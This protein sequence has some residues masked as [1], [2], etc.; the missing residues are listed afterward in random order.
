MNRLLVWKTEIDATGCVTLDPR[1]AK[2]VREVLKA[3]AGD[4]LKAGFVN[5]ALAEACVVSVD[6]TQCIVTMRATNEPLPPPPT[7]DL[8][9]AM[10]RPRFLDRILPQ[11]P[12]LGVRRLFLCDA[13]RVE[14]HY[15]GSQLLKPGNY[16]PVL[17]E[18][19]EQS[20]QPFIPE[21]RLERNLRR[22]LADIAPDYEGHARILA[23]PDGK[24]LAHPDGETRLTRTLALQT[25]GEHPRKPLLLAIGCEGGWVDS[26]IALFDSYG[27]TR[28]SL[29][30]RILRTDTACVALLALLQHP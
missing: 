23:H 14:K 1:R 11:L 2:H 28:L 15:F 25:Q 19:A 9:L 18:G 30:S 6:E 17:V 5:G 13:V 27:F 26:E 8:L 7:I 22:L 21:V 29:G 20:G 10:P 4:V 3:K 24:I 12:P 16:L